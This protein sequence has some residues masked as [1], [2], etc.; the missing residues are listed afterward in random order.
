MQSQAIYLKTKEESNWD[1]SWKLLLEISEVQVYMAWVFQLREAKWK[2]LREPRHLGNNTHTG[3][4]GDKVLHQP[5]HLG[6]NTHTGSLG[7]K[8]LCEPRHLGNNTHTGSLGDKVLREPRHLGNNTHTSSLGDKVLHQPRH[9]EN[10]T[11]TG[12]FGNKGSDDFFCEQLHS[13][14]TDFTILLVKE[15]LHE[16]QQLGYTDWHHWFPQMRP[17]LSITLT[18]STLYVNYW[19][20]L[21]KLP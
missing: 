20:D 17:F 16:Q 1:V 9:L 11:L 5:W 18:P 15:V 6:K 4:L 2:L 14:K 8:V 21:F 12:S 7:D 10:N 13:G 3:S 19:K